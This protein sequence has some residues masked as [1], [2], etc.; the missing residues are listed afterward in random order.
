MST[1]PGHR[2]ERVSLDFSWDRE[3]GAGYLAL[4]PISAGEAVTQRIVASP[5]QGMG[6]V[7]LDFAGDGRVLGIEFLGR[8]LLPPGLHD[9]AG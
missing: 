7:V 8:R 3:A 1:G 2:A 9:S 6:E 4:G 5:V